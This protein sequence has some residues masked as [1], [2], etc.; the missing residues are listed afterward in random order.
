MESVGGI[1]CLFDVL[2]LCV[3]SP[4][5]CRP[6]RLAARGEVCILAVRGGG[7]VL[8]YSSLYSLDQVGAV[9]ILLGEHADNVGVEG[10]LLVKLCVGGDWAAYSNR[11]FSLSV[12]VVDHPETVVA[13]V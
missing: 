10:V 3:V 8:L 7:K 11:G 6:V 12:P 13:I 1:P 4:V 5:S 2:Q 9:S